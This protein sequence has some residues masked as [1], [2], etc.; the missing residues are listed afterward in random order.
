[1]GY[2]QKVHLLTMCVL[3]KY[4]K[5]VYFVEGGCSSIF[6][7]LK[8]YEKNGG[9]TMKVKRI[10][11][12]I[13]MLIAILTLGLTGCKKEVEL[14]SLDKEN[15]VVTH[16]ETFVLNAIVLP[17][18]ADDRSV[19]W[20]LESNIIVYPTTFRNTLQKEFFAA[21]VG[22]TT[23]RVISS[24]GKYATC[25]VTVTENEEDKAARE[26]EAKAKEEAAREKEAEVKAK[27]ESQIV[28][29]KKVNK[30]VTKT[31]TTG[32]QT[33]SEDGVDFSELTLTPNEVITVKIDNTTQVAKRGY[34]KIA[35]LDKDGLQL[36]QSV[37]TF[38][39]NALTNDIIQSD[40]VPSG[41][42]SVKFLGT[43]VVDK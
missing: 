26:K 20:S 22:K 21:N 3:K 13:A 24:N 32:N 19:V 9:I 11:S 37:I 4:K 2:C 8:Y 7:K 36:K 18:D 40:R 6:G 5:F 29:E 10:F 39:I 25:N 35:C 34:V 38:E 28:T 15:F 27:E 17:N 33:M 14:I 31:T 42:V 30:P 23:V 12:M 41:T 43:I 16:G 1:M